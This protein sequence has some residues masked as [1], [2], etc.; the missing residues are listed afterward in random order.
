MNEKDINMIVLSNTLMTDTRF[1]AD[2]EWL[3]FLNHFAKFGFAK[4]KV[5]NTP[6]TL[7]V[8]SALLKKD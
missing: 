6:R 3:F 2:K 4:I 1:R 7:L 8:K 5:P